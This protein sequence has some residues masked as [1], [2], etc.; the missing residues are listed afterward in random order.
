MM[1]LMRKRGEQ[2]TQEGASENPEKLK[3]NNECC[4]KHY[5]PMRNVPFVETSWAAGNV[6]VHGM[7]L[8]FAELPALC[9]QCVVLVFTKLP[10][11]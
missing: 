10:V 7:G 5:D 8:V 3:R 4:P 6:S 2:N 1:N 9:S 11:L